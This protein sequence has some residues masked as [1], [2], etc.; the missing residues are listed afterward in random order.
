[1]ENTFNLIFNTHV[2]EDFTRKPPYLFHLRFYD[3]DE[4]RVF[5]HRGETV[6]KSDDP[7][8]DIHRTRPRQPANHTLQR[9]R[10]VRVSHVLVGDHRLGN[11]VHNV[12]GNILDDPSEGDRRLES[13]VVDVRYDAEGKVQRFS[14]DI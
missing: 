10:H 6:E 7:V 12:D 1:M 8:I 14:W 13:D 5:V 3:V 2:Y 11:H 4:D 9:H